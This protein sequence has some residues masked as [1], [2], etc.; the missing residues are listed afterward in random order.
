MAVIKIIRKINDWAVI[1]AIAL[2]S[3]VV[4]AQVFARYLSH[5]PLTW[6]EEF[7]RYCQ[8]WMVMLGSACMMRKGGHLAIDLLTAAL[9]APVKRVTDFISYVA[10]IVFFGIVVYQGLFVTM[11]AAAQTSPAMGL[12]MSYVYAALPVGGALILMEAIIRFV[13][14]LRTGSADEPTPDK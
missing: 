7:A 11:N 1:I 10:V 6:S 2:L 9:P 3:I 14:F 13:R 8:I 12:H 4:I 5:Q